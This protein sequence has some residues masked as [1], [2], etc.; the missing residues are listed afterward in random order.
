MFVITMPTCVNKNL[1]C[2]Q[3]M[4]ENTVHELCSPKHYTKSCMR[5]KLIL[6]KNKDS[7]KG[8]DN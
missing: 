2:C 8:V 7:Y 3:E 4:A 5:E 6:L 1:P